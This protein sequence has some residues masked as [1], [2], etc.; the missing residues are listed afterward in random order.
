VNQKDKRCLN[1]FKV[2]SSFTKMASST[3]LNPEKL[4]KL[5]RELTRSSSNPSISTHMVTKLMKHVDPNDGSFQF[6]E[7]AISTE[8]KCSKKDARKAF[9]DLTQAGAV[10][11]AFSNNN[12]H[13][14]QFEKDLI[15]LHTYN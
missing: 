7:K 12:K 6:D 13:F 8:L 3:L 5:F 2:G 11:Y 4:S 9:E 14:Y 15:Q 1:Y 10:L